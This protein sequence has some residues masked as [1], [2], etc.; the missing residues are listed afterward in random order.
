MLREL[1]NRM[2]KEINGRSVTLTLTNKCN[3]N[4]T[5]CYEF[6]KNCNKMSIETARK[7][8]DLETSQQSE[9][10]IIFE[11]FGGEPFLEFDLI[12]EIY[13]YVETKKT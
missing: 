13:S 2:N 4:C 10:M 11:L 6:G 12:K 1:N 8:I 5:Y 3:L 7:I 9:S